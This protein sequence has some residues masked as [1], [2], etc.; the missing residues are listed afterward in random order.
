MAEQ[1]KGILGMFIAIIVALPLLLSMVS[2]IN[3]QTELSSVTNEEINLSDAYIAADS[4]NESVEFTLDYGYDTT[5][6]T[7]ISS[8][9]LGNSSDDATE[10]T[11]YVVNLTEGTFTLKN[12]TFWQS[13]SDQLGYADYDYKASSYMENSFPRLITGLII[14]FAALV[15]LAFLV[16][17]IVRMF[18]Y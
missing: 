17:W 10:T 9:V 6:N 5:G 1:M 11:D 13:T 2:L 12:S 4:I 15:I 7:P 3:P 18:N 14:G 16:A 8:F